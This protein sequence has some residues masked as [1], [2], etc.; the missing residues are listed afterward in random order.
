MAFDQYLA[1]LRNKLALQYPDASDAD[2]ERLAGISAAESGN[3]AVDTIATPGL[4]TN[5]GQ[6]TSVPATQATW[7]TPALLDSLAYVESRNN[8]LAVSPAGARGVY[9][10]MPDTAAQPGYGVTP[11]TPQEVLDP[12]KAREFARQYLE[13]LQKAYPNYTPAEILQAYNAGPGRMAKY[14]NGIGPA[15]AVETQL[16]AGKVLSGA[17]LQGDPYTNVDGIITRALRDPRTPGINDPEILRLTNDAR[18]AQGKLPY[19]DYDDM[20]AAMDANAMLYRT[21]NQQT[22]SAMREAS[23]VKNADGDWRVKLRLAPQATYLYKASDPGILAPLTV[24]DGVIFPYTP[25]IDVQYRSDYNSYQPTHSNYMHYFYK[26]SSV[27]TVQLTAD[28]TAQDTVEAEYLLA[29]MHFFKSASKMF[30]GQDAE[31]GSPPPL[32]YLSG[33]GEYQFNESPC[34]ISEFNLNLPADVNYIRARS[35]QI[36]GA[37]NLQYQK[38]LATSATNGNFSSLTR[39]STAFTALFGGGSQPLQVG[40]QPYTPSPGKLGSKGATYV[41]TKMSMTINLLPIQSRQQVSQQFS[42]KEYANGNLIKK[43]MW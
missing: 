27:Q 43:G 1:D 18:I 21:Q 29:V 20:N 38:P 25:Q 15:L 30:Y 5:Y 17:G 7:V 11:L 4:N 19:A 34:V 8:P 24:T 26:G 42:L 10:I 28:F 14:K 37:D 23:G 2:L 16:Y 6:L 35:R 40:A 36:T 33:L 41:P 3:Y 13:G 31:R 12:V 9:Q 39:L 32:L 22:V